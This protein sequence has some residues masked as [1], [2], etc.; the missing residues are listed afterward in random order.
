[1]TELPDTEPTTSAGPEPEAEVYEYVPSPEQEQHAR[2]WAYSM[3][4]RNY[5]L[6]GPLDGYTLAIYQEQVVDKDR[7]YRELLARVTKRF[8]IEDW[9]VLLIDPEDVLM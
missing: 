5:G 1:M 8:G 2:D 3:Y 4:L 7:D 9:Q 6:H